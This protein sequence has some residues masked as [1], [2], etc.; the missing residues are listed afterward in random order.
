MDSARLGKPAPGFKLADASGKTWNLLQFRD[1][2]AVVL[3]FLGV[4]N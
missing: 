3:I 2:K 4:H 1:K